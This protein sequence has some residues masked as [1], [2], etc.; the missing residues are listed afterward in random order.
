[1]PLV[2][3]GANYNFFDGLSSAGGAAWFALLLPSFAYTANEDSDGDC[4]VPGCFRPTYVV[5]TAFSA[6]ATLSALYLTR[7]AL[8]QAPAPGEPVG[9]RSSALPGDMPADL[10]VRSPVAAAKD[11]HGGAQYGALAGVLSPLPEASREYDS[12]V[13]VTSASA[14]SSAESRLRSAVPLP[15]NSEPNGLEKTWSSYHSENT[16]FSE[17]SR[18]SET[19]GMEVDE[20][21]SEYGNSTHGSTLGRNLDGIAEA[22]AGAHA[23]ETHAA[24][25]TARTPV[26]V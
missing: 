26:D 9:H 10:P 15:P 19:T 17:S 1:M 22:H 18:L 25:L 24:L 6:A 13:T 16:Q 20:E 4:T 3:S 7:V 12:P 2:C 21:A 14:P 11:P 5:I 8:A 23:E